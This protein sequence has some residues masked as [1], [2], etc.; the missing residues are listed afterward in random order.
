MKTL[1][2]FLIFIIAVNIHAGDGWTT[3]FDG[4][5]LSQWQPT[6]GNWSIEDGKVL[7]IEPREGEEGW[8]RYDC[9]LYS[10]KQYSDFI[11]EYEY[12][13]NKG[14]NSGLYFRI[15]KKEDGT[16]SGMEV[17][18]LDCYGKQG[19]PT[20][21]DNGGIIGTIGASK[22]MSEPPNEWNKAVLTAKGKHLTLVLN[23]EK[24]VD[25]DYSK[26][27]S[28]KDKPLKGYFGLQ[29]HGHGN[30]IRFR[31]IRIKELK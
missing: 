13:Y 2:T 15:E 18:I 30:I 1:Y 3:L 21:H 22:N 17:Q 29:D 4:T 19:K 9:Y 7:K 10:K 28:V 14:G 24:V 20:H 12:M 23:G 31:N 8:S 11:I 25:F 16:I 26:T 27:E 5:D 6:K